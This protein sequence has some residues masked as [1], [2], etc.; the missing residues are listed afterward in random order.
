MQVST[1]T[2]STDATAIRRMSTP[3]PAKR[4]RAARGAAL[5][6]AALLIAG[7]AAVPAFRDAEGLLDGR[8]A[9]PLALA[10]CALLVGAAAGTAFAA[11]AGWAAL[12]IAGQAVS[13][14]LVRA[15]MMIGHQ[16]YVPANELPAAG[17]LPLLGFLAAQ[18]VVVVAAV[19]GRV[20]ASLT[21]ARDAW[22]GWRL[23]AVAAVFVL[24]A[25]T[26][27]RSIPIYGAELVFASAIQLLHLLTLLLA[28]GALPPSAL[29]TVRAKTDALLG[30]R[31]GAAAGGGVDRVALGAAL[32]VLAVCAL[33]AW[34][35]YQNHPHVPDE[36][37]YLYHARYFADGM[38]ALPAP[39][40]PEA[41]N[42]DLM[43][44]EPTRWYSPVPP[45]W[46]AALSVGVLLGVPWLVNPALNAVNV[47]L[48][49]LLLHAVYDRRSARLGVL[50]LAVSPWFLFMGM[51]FMTHT[52]TLTCALAAAV[53][54][55]RL[56]AG[57]S[58]GWA[59][60]GGL[61][62]GVMGSIRPLE[63]LTVAVLLGLWS[64]G[65]WPWSAS[66]FARTAALAAMSIVAGALTLPYNTA[67]AGDPLTFPLMAY[68]DSVYGAG[69]NALGFGA[70]RGLGWPGLDP[71]MGH[72]AIDVLV[73]A[74]LNAHGVNIEL[75][76]WAI[77]SLLP[78][79]LLVLSRRLS[80]ADGWMLAV[81][82]AIVGVHSFYWFSGGPDFGARYWYMILVP[83]V[84]LTARAFVVAGELLD[85]RAAPDVR[86]GG[87]R[88]LVAAGALALAAL[89]AFVPWRAIDKYYHYRNMR[90]D[91]RRIAEERDFGRSLVLVR[92]RRHP[93]YASAA[94]YNPL[95]LRGDGPVY[96]WDRDPAITRR[97]LEAYADRPVW[98]LDGPT[99]TGG[100]FAVVGGPVSAASLLDAGPG[101]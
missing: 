86:W 58:I 13:L 42:I 75:F 35:A 3:A 2:R 48:A 88:A 9:L 81:V 19:R 91:V 50:L 64:L 23:A 30:T 77:G 31:A 67:L 82:A 51:N 33:L 4:V 87:P 8:A 98:I 72:G 95:D 10:A 17:S 47:L 68:T 40:V 90:P 43:T 36:V 24:T 56:R 70:N 18:A 7:A 44:Y 78:I 96:I 99:R 41:F 6:V 60:A 57:R 100:G 38:L 92:G 28:V 54:V 61:A 79:A 76:G 1:K 71:F 32:W 101:R 45:G 63:G 73:N 20:R 83:C 85:E 16:H 80:R 29:A 34:F 11:A 22:P 14:Q 69:T 39:P 21:F 5:V 27:S 94:I 52:F 62:I 59:A 12:M 65:G 74:N 26:L 49:F 84:A 15:G 55:A 37:I 66:R 25:A 89:V 46:P 53:A 93:D 97:A